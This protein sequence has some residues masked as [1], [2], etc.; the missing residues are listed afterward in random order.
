M[1]NTHPTATLPAVSGGGVA[2]AAAILTRLTAGSP[3]T[4]I[5]KLEATLPI[6]PIWLMSLMWLASFV[7]F[8]AAAGLLL[9]FPHGNPQREA[10]L[11]RGNTF[12]VLAM[13]F[14]LGWYTLLFGKFCLLP[15][16]L[17]LLLSAAAALACA[18]AWMQLKRNASVAALVFS[19]WQ[20]FL[21]LLQCAVL[22]H[23]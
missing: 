16:C 20:I 11:W 12:M 19:L 7:L 14:S 2:L 17:C 1:K 18:L 4:V 5:H 23:A 3:L 6:P 21:F 10:S 15:S 13:V 8:G 22:F 9:V